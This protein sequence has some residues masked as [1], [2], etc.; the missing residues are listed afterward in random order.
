MTMKI[1]L[2]LPDSVFEQVEELAQTLGMSRSKLYLKAL[3]AYLQK[4]N[5]DQ[6]PSKLNG[7]CSK[8]ADFR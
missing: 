4:H 3:E 1:S 5:R 7:H 6:L 2:S 8:R